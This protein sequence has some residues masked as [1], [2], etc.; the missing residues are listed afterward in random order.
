MLFLMKILFK[1][2]LLPILISLIIPVIFLIAMYQPMDPYY[3]D[4]DQLESL[5]FEEVISDG[6]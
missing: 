6:V 4:N 2:I 5:V 3:K 1:Y